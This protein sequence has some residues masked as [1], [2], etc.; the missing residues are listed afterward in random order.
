MTKR[1]FPLASGAGLLLLA[2]ACLSPY[3]PAPHFN[4][5]TV[6][7]PAATNA[8]VVKPVGTTNAQVAA[9]APGSRVLRVAE[10]AAKT[11]FATA[12]I[13]EDVHTLE[14]DVW[15][16]QRQQA[17][18]A[19]LN[20]VAPRG[21]FETLAAYQARVKAG[22][23]GNAT[24]A[25]ALSQVLYLARDAEF[26][27]NIDTEQFL[28]LPARTTA[29]LATAAGATVVVP[30]PVVADE[31]AGLILIANTLYNQGGF[32][33]AAEVYSKFQQ[34]HPQHPL[35]DKARLGLA[36]AHFQRGLFAEAAPL[37]AAL[38]KLENQPDKLLVDT[39]LAQCNLV[40]K[41]GKQVKS[42]LLN[43]YRMEPSK[44][45]E[46]PA[47]KCSGCDQAVADE[48]KVPAAPAPA[49]TG[50]S[51]VFLPGEMP[52]AELT[53]AHWANADAK[54]FE[55]GLLSDLKTREEWLKA[56]LAPGQPGF[57]L[58]GKVDA[59][60]AEL[61]KPRL[62]V[63]AGYRLVSP[64]QPGETGRVLEHCQ[65]VSLHVMDATSKKIY[66]ECALTALPATAIP[67]PAAH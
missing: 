45:A 6:K 26:L 38:A 48:P 57:I 20:T 36:L 46:S 2:V 41:E 67:K 44:D 62:R 49:A 42:V 23:G 34:L 29:A 54:F 60:T 59:K 24:T 1:V 65:V 5:K 55:T 8:D 11:D 15:A 52:P 40:L 9:A 22:R 39:L 66:F 47:P 4:P 19:A 13:Y 7:F 30:A 28:V 18:Q 10:L 37:L 21:E 51:G 53:L 17:E 63:V 25:A 35:A 14:R 32:V 16:A 31:A 12:R 43:G 56:H 33:V 3:K 50:M 27:Y 64:L 61:L 58:T